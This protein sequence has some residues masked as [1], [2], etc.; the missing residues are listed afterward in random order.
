M[1][2]CLSYLCRTGVLLGA[3]VDTVHDI[4][5]PCLYPTLKKKYSVFLFIKN[6]LIMFIKN[7][8]KART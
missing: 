4:V 3:V 2:K 5:Y 8:L 6:I 1:A 7:I